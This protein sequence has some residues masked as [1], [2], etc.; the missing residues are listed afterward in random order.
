MT[1]ISGL[2]TDLQLAGLGRDETGLLGDGGFP[3]G[4]AGHSLSRQTDIRLEGN[5]LRWRWDSDA[6]IAGRRR[7]L[8]TTGMLDRFI[9][10]RNARGVLRF[11]LR[12][13]TLALCEHGMPCSHRSA[14]AQWTR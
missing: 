7:F 11:A 8:H 5:I 2:T 1:Y 9:Q 3:L 10:I 4:I 14:D 13:G 6:A 12:F